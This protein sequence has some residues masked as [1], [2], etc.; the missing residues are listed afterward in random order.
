MSSP[1]R[2][3]SISNRSTGGSATVGGSRTHD[4]IG[5]RVAVEVSPAAVE[6]VAYAGQRVGAEVCREEAC[7]ETAQ[8]RAV[9]QQVDLRCGLWAQLENGGRHQDRP[10]GMAGEHDGRGR[11]AGQCRDP[12]GQFGDGPLAVGGG[13]ERMGGA[14]E[15][16]A[17]IPEDA[18]GPAQGHVAVRVPRQDDQAE[19]EQP[20]DPGAERGQCRQRRLLDEAPVVRAGRVHDESGEEHRSADEDDAS[21]D[22]AHPV[23]E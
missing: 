21:D 6:P 12:V 22:A 23:G 16:G 3:G 20:H 11:R 5:V 7:V 8:R 18:D 9:S 19:R 1:S 17:D 15:E 2:R 4:P 10:L 13:C 14:G